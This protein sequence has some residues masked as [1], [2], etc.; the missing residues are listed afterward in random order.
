MK[1]FYPISFGG[2]KAAGVTAMQYG[3]GTGGMALVYHHEKAGTGAYAV[4]LSGLTETATY[5]V[6]DVDAPSA[7]VTLTGAAL[8]AGDFTVT[9]PAGKKAVIVKYT[10]A[11]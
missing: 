11:S 5:K 4:P 1:D 8:M 6:W 2:V 7:A 3:D 9:L 10:L